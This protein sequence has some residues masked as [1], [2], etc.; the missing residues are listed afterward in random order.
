[1]PMRNP[2]P[3]MTPRYEDIERQYASLPRRE[4]VEP[5]EY[6][7]QPWAGHRDP[8][9]YPNPQS[10]YQPSYPPRNNY[11]RPVDPRQNDSG[12]HH[13]PPQQRGPLRQ[14]VPPS[15]TIPLQGPCFD[16]MNRGGYRNT[17]PERYAYGEV[18]HSDPRQKSP[19]TAAV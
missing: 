1:M 8:A 9:P 5:N 19:M 12:F 10:G 3:I 16:T 4:P 6:S 2:D 17:S 15:P 7:M 14:D 11:P 13:P 18:R